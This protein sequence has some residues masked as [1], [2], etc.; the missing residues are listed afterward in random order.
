MRRAGSRPRAPHG[1]GAAGSRLLRLGPAF[2]AA[3]AYV[4]PGNIATNTTAGSRYGFALLWVVLLA[5]TAAGPVQYLSAKLGAVTGQS[6][7]LVL[8]TRLG[9]PGRILYWLQAEGV[10]IAT[11]LAEVVG[12]SIALHL[13]FG[14]PLWC[15]A[16]VTAAVGATLMALRDRVGERGFQLAM[17]LGL[18][19]IGAGFILGVLLGP[20]PAGLDLRPQLRDQQMV[21]LATGIVGATVMPHA[22]YLHSALTTSQLGSIRRRLRDNRLD[23]TLAM[24]V[25]GTV[26]VSMLVLGAT[27]LRGHRDEDFGALAHALADRVGDG[28]RIGFILA[29]LVSGVTSTAVGIRSGEVVMAGLLRRRVPMLVRRVVVLIPAVVLLA[30]EVPAVDLLVWS[31]VAL[32]LGLPLALIP[33]VLLTSSASVMGEQVN[34]R[35][36]TVVCWTITSA[37]VALDVALLAIPLVG[38]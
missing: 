8:S 21:L 37:V 2:V 36:M 13:L 31:Q 35:A 1:P 20:T 23:V 34:R 16:I 11:D 24:L 10:A 6:M 26:N 9:R 5:V 18:A 28:A 33:L 17:L 12:A 3:I 7:A 32:A 25:A 38:V 15:G 30:C 4:D 27:A 14:V 19:L 29:L 22:I